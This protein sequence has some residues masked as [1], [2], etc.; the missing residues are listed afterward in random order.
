M[1]SDEEVGRQILSI[2]M[3]HKVGA[4]G[5]LRRNNFIDVRDA[6]FQRGLNKAVE[7]RWIKVKLRDRYTYELTEAG[8]AAGLNARLPSK[9]LGWRPPGAH[10]AEGRREDM[11]APVVPNQFEV[12]KNKIV[13]KPIITEK[14]T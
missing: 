10:L 9:P 4:S 2:F 14:T 12:G 8:L 6:D 11:I 3:Q 13:H 7:N 5:V 1:A